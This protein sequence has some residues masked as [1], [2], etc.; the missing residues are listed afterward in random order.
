M[1]EKPVPPPKRGQHNNRN[2][3]MSPAPPKGGETIEEYCKRT[4][5]VPRYNIKDGKAV[6][7]N[8]T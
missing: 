7:N 6:I 3:P 1:S 8:D 5:M 2:L 4:G